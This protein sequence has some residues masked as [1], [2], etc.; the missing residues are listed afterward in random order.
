MPFKA[1]RGTGSVFKYTAFLLILHNALEGFAQDVYL[2]VWRNPER[3]MTRLFPDAKDY[4]TEIVKISHDMRRQIEKKLGFELLPGQRKTFQYFTLLDGKS[5]TL[6]IVIAAS[7][8]GRFGA[9]EFVVGLDTLNTINGLYIQ[10]SRERQRNFK[11]RAFLD[12]FIGQKI[13]P[14]E[15]LA[16]LH[17]GEETPG[18]KAVIRGLQ[19]EFAC[20]THLVQ[21]RE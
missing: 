7:Q 2:C 9:I 19:K 1:I 21:R 20:Y 14:V 15:K 3:T 11:K 13:R 6:G 5:Q 4:K 8:K 18:T 10:R 16:Q 17:K 12:L